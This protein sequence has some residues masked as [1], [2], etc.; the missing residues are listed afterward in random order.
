[1]KDL[2]DYLCGKPLSQSAEPIKE[3]KQVQSAR[4]M[5]QPPKKKGGFHL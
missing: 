3:K 4:R 2:N 5:M 1:Y